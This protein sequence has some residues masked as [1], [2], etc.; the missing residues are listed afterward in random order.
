MMSVLHRIEIVAEEADFALAQAL[1]SRHVSAGWEEESLPG[2]KTRFLAHCGEKSVLEA[3]AGDLGRFVPAVPCAFS[4]L[5]VQ[6]WTDAWRDFFTPV[7]AGLFLILPPWL[8][9]TPPAGRIPLIVEPKSAFGTGHHPSTTLCL[10]AVSRLHASG[11]LGP[12]RR[13]LDLGTGT[14][15][16]GMACAKLG[17][18]GLCLDIDP[19]AVSNAE[20]NRVL[21]RLEDALEIR[22]GSV[23]DADGGPFDLILANILAPPLQEMARPVINLL[24]PD[25]CLVLSG[26]LSGRTSGVE[27]AYAELGTP[28]CL[29]EPSA[30]IRG[31][32]WACLVWRRDGA[33]RPVRPP[34]S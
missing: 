21:N 27:H 12:G 22:S 23:R 32:A 9:G 16:L 18:S 31:D 10:E 34:L 2:G 24:K 1:V 29:T 25:G 17:L 5:P 26:F 4:V 28:E 3:L 20:E 15:I 7:A 8:A 33:P 14:G 19:L 6:D 13:F 30:V 11:A